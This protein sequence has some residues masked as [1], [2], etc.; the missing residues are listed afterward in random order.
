MSRVTILL[1]LLF[2]LP[3]CH[4]GAKQK[5]WTVG[6]TLE[7]MVFID[8][9]GQKRVIDETTRMIIFAA[10]RAAAKQVHAAIETQGADY[11]MTQR[12]IYVADISRMPWLIARIFAI[13]RMQDYDYPIALG[14]KSDD[15][16]EFPRQKGKVSLIY[17]EQQKLKKIIFVTTADMILPLI[18]NSQ[19]L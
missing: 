4:V 17:L 6:Q 11:L 1:L 14:R 15:C 9:H 3:I 12:V 19:S 7:S 16:V 13:P 18:E 5:T 10:D 2:V 8:Q